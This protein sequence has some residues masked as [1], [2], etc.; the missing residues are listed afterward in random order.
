MEL[1]DSCMSRMSVS[2]GVLPTSRMKKSWDMRFA[3]TALSEGRRRRRRPKRCGWVGYCMRSYSVRATWAFSCRLSTWA[4]SVSPHASIRDRLVS[5]MLVR[6][7]H[8]YKCSPRILQNS[9][10]WISGHF[11]GDEKARSHCWWHLFHIITPWIFFFLKV[12]FYIDGPI[13]KM[14][15]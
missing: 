5:E 7:R 14:Y 6:N 2:M 1:P 8:S 13:P 11:G 9:A 4:G 10:D 15:G 3:G 12:F